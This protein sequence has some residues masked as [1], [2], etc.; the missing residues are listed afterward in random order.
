MTIPELLVKDG[1]WPDTRGPR[2]AS[3]S[4][5]ADVQYAYLTHDSKSNLLIPVCYEK[6]FLSQAGVAI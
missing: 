1:R 5:V 6:Q 3:K 2:K 4:K